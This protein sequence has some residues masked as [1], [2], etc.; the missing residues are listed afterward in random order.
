MFDKCLITPSSRF[1]GAWMAIPILGFSAWKVLERAQ[2]NVGSLVLQQ[3]HFAQTHTYCL[4]WTCE[5]LL[6]CSSEF[7]RVGFF[8]LFPIVHHWYFISF[9]LQGWGNILLVRIFESYFK[10]YFVLFNLPLIFLPELELIAK[11]K[12]LQ[13]KTRASKMYKRSLFFHAVKSL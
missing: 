6:V 13:V 9:V 3:L 1:Q 12:H 10:T 2:E 4:Q 5:N 11:L 8:P 7:M